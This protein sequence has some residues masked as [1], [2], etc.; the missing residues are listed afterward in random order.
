MSKVTQL[1]RG[2]E[3]RMDLENILADG[4]REVEVKIHAFSLD[5]LNKVGTQE[6]ISVIMRFGSMRQ[7]AGVKCQ[8][9]ES[10]LVRCV[11]K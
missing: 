8:T 3:L 11:C 5:F 6:E 4:Q 2:T 1:I 10:V 9:P 7:P